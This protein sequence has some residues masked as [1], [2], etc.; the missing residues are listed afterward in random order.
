MN[1][2][3]RYSGVPTEPIRIFHLPY[4]QV[5]VR[6]DTHQGIPIPRPQRHNMMISMGGGGTART[7]TFDQGIMS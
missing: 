4:T 1:K 6:H 7:R 2:R 3:R 5:Q